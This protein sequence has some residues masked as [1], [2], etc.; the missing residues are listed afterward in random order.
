M[1]TSNDSTTV[2]TPS[3]L[4]Q[5]SPSTNPL[6]SSAQSGY[7]SLLDSSET[8]GEIFFFNS[9]ELI[10]IFHEDGSVSSS[11][12]RSTTNW[13][14]T[15]DTLRQWSSR[16]LKYTRQLFQERFGHFIRTQDVEL[17]QNIQVH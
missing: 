7:V 4:D 12:Q 8:P 13:S 9:L 3:P 14:R 15:F 5:N 6:S 2:E 1:S 17:E 16:T 11:A 10:D